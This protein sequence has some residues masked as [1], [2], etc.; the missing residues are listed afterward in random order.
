MPKT[1]AGFVN[2]KTLSGE[3]LMLLM[4]F[5]A[6]FLLAWRWR[7]IYS[8]IQLEK[9]PSFPSSFFSLPS[10]GRHHFL[11]PWT[12][13]SIP[14][15]LISAPRLLNLPFPLSCL[16]SLNRLE[17]RVAGV[18]ELYELCS[19]SILTLLSVFVFTNG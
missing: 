8:G 5:G 17:K 12:T 16:A 19:S 11:L 9:Q 18:Y 14:P 15:S 2:I 7:N 10:L 1:L 6:N 13:S 4:H 3:K